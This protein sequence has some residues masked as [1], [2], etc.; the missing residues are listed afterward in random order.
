MDSQNR[1]IEEYLRLRDSEFWK[2]YNA[3]LAKMLSNR[4]DKLRNGALET[5]LYTQGEVKALEIVAKLPE[6]II[7][8]LAENQKEVK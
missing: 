7:S 6:S 2:T 5:I 4:I 3:E 1:I 8:A